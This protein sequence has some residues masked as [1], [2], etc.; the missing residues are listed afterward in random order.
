MTTPLPKP[1]P[2]LAERIYRRL[3]THFGG[4]QLA[5]T[6]GIWPDPKPDLL[7]AIREEIAKGEKR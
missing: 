3:F 7:A 5:M 4:Q 2:D 1:K 6:C